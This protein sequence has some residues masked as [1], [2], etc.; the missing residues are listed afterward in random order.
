MCMHQKKTKQS[1][2]IRKQ[3]LTSEKRNRKNKQKINDTVADL[4]AYIITLNVN[5]LNNMKQ[6]SPQSMG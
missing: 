2:K 5:G 1:F 6:K 3:N 4:S